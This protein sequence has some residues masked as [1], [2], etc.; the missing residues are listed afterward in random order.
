MNNTEFKISF[1]MLLNFYFYTRL[2]MSLYQRVEYADGTA[3]SDKRSA[4]STC[5]RSMRQCKRLDN[6]YV[7][8]KR[9]K[10]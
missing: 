8:V 1:L 6:I 5:L 3:I 2:V 7:A 4:R 10:L 9:I